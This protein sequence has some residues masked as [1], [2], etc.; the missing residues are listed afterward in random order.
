MARIVSSDRSDSSNLIF[1]FSSRH[2]K[3]IKSSNSINL[4]KTA[5][6]IFLRK[7]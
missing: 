5:K 6:M 1:N 3:P 7:E 4:F 2:L